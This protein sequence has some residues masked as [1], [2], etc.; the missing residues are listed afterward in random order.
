MVV[1]D[2]VTLRELDSVHY[3]I[4]PTATVP[5][6]N[7]TMTIEEPE[8]GALFVRFSYCARYLENIG[9]GQPYDLYVQQAY[10]AADID[11]ISE[12]RSRLQAAH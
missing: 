4:V 9:D 3:E 6:G 2:H 12:I 10:V 7:L 5:G 11:T 8:V 1:D